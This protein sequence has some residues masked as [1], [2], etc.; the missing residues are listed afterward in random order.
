MVTT[1]YLR[2]L[3]ALAL[4]LA[5]IALCAWLARRF[6]LGGLAASVVGSGRLRVLETLA[7]DGRQRLVLI[8]RDDCEHLLFIGQETVQIIERNIERLNDSAVAPAASLPAS[9]R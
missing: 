6:R 2:F 3:L 8:R 7:I 5:L 9:N 1:D 4:V